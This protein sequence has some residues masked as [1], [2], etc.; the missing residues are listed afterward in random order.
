MKLEKLQQALRI[1]RQG[2]S[3]KFFQIPVVLTMPEI[4]PKKCSLATVN[5]NDVE[6]WKAPIDDPVKKSKRGKL[7]LVKRDGKYETVQN[8]QKETNLDCCLIDT[9]ENGR[10]LVDYNLE[11]IRWR[12]TL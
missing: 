4:N 9:F 1:S 11:T 2:R 6:V 7:A 3:L 10:L 5:G 8:A 12:C